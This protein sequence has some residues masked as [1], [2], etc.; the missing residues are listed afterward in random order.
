ML[1]ARGQQSVDVFW[2][3]MP[4]ATYNNE[5]P[6]GWQ[7]KARTLLLDRVE[8]AVHDRGKARRVAVGP[9]RVRA[10]EEGVVLFGN[11]QATSSVVVVVEHVVADNG[12]KRN[13]H[14][15]RALNALCS[16]PSSTCG[17]TTAA[18]AIMMALASS[19]LGVYTM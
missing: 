7:G 5:T 4:Y 2:E 13:T 1:C 10:Q 6:A 15:E 12:T 8:R 18:Q 3:P 11:L 9:R 14:T 17:P 16:S 19:A